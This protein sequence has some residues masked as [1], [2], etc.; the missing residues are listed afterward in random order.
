MTEIFDNPSFGESK[1]T[2]I[3][4]PVGRRAANKKHDI[5]SR[6]D[7]ANYRFSDQRMIQH[8]EFAVS[9]SQTIETLL[10]NIS[11]V[12]SDQSDCL[13]F[14]VCQQ[15]K[16]G[17]IAS[18]H[19]LTEEGGE[20]WVVA[21][22]LAEQMIER[23]AKT[24][25]VCSS[26]LN[27]STGTELVAAPVAADTN[28]ETPISMILIGCFSSVK[29]SVLRQQWLLGLVSQTIVRWQQKRSLEHLELKTK[30]LNDTVG[31]IH[32]LDRTSSVGEAAMVVANHLRRSCNAEQ[33]SV[34]LGESNQFCLK[35]ISDVEKVDEN[36]EVSKVVLNACQQVGLLRETI[37]FPAS[38]DQH[39]VHQL[40][41]G[42]YCKSKGFEACLGLP[43]ITAEGELIGTI[44]VG[45]NQAQ[46]SDKNFREYLDRFVSLMTGHLAIVIRANQGLCDL[47]KSR[48]Q[49]FRKSRLTLT[50]LL[51]V[52]FLSALMLVPL[53][54]RIGCDCE[55]QP[56][57]RRFVA[58]PHDG[59]LEKTFVESGQIVAKDQVVAHLDGAQLRIELAGLK[60]EYEGAKKARSSALGK[61]EVA[62]SQIAGSEMK[63]HQAKINLLEDQLK[64]LE[65]KAPIS[66]M[67]V[68]GDLEKVE[69]APLEMG[70]T[71]FEI[72]PLDNMLAEIGIPESEIHYAKP[73]MTVAIKLNAFPYKTWS[74]T[75]ERIHPRTE[76][77]EDDS[78]FIA[79]VRLP[80]LGQQLRPGMKGSA[81][82]K[83]ELSPIGWNLFHQ[84][85]ESVRYWMIW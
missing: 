52:G 16:M 27:C 50:I 30:S 23:I 83:S 59:I 7:S 19:L 76:V 39:A 41:L 46:Y 36:S 10:T 9:T 31:I 67:V 78:V 49:A 43:L 42:K 3:N 2:R 32:A 20:L 17:Q 51:T 6:I 44:L 56:V 15:N 37:G 33:V 71:L 69:G 85:W 62:V 5:N 77:V 25:Q 48:W 13:A 22:D 66:G 57:L 64:N 21:E 70:K 26:P 38:G 73:G 53:P 14:W 55:I 35:A 82:V 47:L 80:N 54:Y 11:R 63:R 29:Q 28:P 8:L 68:S 1:P 4:I 61:G 65:V 81:K 24:R 79:E 58:S 12:V 34:A 45:L 18:P 72:A 75:I 60:A 74:G 84:S 40:A